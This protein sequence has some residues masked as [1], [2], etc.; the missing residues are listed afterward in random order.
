VP[1]PSP[2]PSPESPPVA[3]S[4]A[5][6][7][8]GGPRA[9][10][11]S[12]H[13]RRDDG[14]LPAL[15][16]EWDDLYARC[17]AATP[18]QSSAW[19]RSWWQTYGRSG[20]LRLALVRQGGR[21]MAAAPLMAVRRRGCRVLAPVGEGLSDFTDI[22]LD[23]RCGAEAARRLA[24]LLAG[25]PGW[26]VLDFPEVRPLAAVHRLPASLP[27]QVWRLDASM[28]LQL[29]ARPV[30]ETVE[31]L[32]APAA[33]KL[34]RNLRKID[35]LGV[36][37]T[38]VSP[39]MAEAAMAGLIR[40]HRLQWTGRGV[41]PEHLRP[42]FAEHLSRVARVLIGD[43]RAA[44]AEYRMDGRLVA[45]DFSLVGTDFVGGYLYGAH[46]ELR[47]IDILAL[48]LR[49]NLGLTC[50]LGRPVLSFMRGGEAYKTKWRP[51]A[52]PNQR[53]VIGR[54]SRSRAYT[55]LVRGGATA[56]DVVK[57]RFPGLAESL[58]AGP[59]AWPVARAV[60]QTVAKSVARPRREGPG[61]TEEHR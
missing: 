2:V 26:D 38:P 1:S 17:G 37:I 14:A 24:D 48:L 59:G 51:E 41:N 60:A 34:R 19:L 50:E 30:G 25:E 10:E 56:R 7:S 27:G 40:L 3:L 18:F 52:V 46:P 20:R 39:D 23:D 15:A 45:A 9:E 28:C 53:L 43:G 47:R 31:R 44:M 21:L 58:R 29:P 16:A 5:P 12:G 42:A 8:S 61:W 55:A 49:R 13:V 22:L 33:G 57:T 4:P 6:A 36:T 54:G 35:K 32:P 11:W